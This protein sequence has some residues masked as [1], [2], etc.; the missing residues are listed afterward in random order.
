MEFVHEIF[1]DEVRPSDHVDWVSE[2]RHEDLATDLIEVVHDALVDFHE[3]NFILDV[4]TIKNDVIIW[5]WH[6]WRSCSQ[7]ENTLTFEILLRL[8]GKTNNSRGVLD[9]EQE[10]RTTILAEEFFQRFN[11]LFVC[12]QFF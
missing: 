8:R 4:I 10:H 12:S 9:R 6:F 11:V 1:G 5:I 2:D 7:S 3:N